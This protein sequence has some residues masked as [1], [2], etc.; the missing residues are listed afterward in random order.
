MD[1]VLPPF[2][3][4]VLD[5][6][7][8]L[9]E[10]HLPNRIEGIYLYGSIALGAYI[11]NSSDIDFISVVNHPLNNEEIKIVSE[12][13][14]TVLSKYPKSDMM[15]S[16]LQWADLGKDETKIQPYP[17]FY[18]GKIHCA[19]TCDINPVTW[20][21]LKHYGINLLGPSPKSL[22]FLPHKKDF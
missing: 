14:Q 1:T 4:T 21:V 15:E 3:K 13:H 5:D 8:S 7:S 20:W 16:Y 2:V 22:Q 19:G 18:E 12:I 10:K 11:E 9:I 17:Y 6:Y